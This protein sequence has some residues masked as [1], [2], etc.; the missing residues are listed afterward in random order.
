MRHLTR[1]PALALLLVLAL[2]LAP[3]A[4]A[5]CGGDDAPAEEQPAQSAFV[6]DWAPVDASLDITW[7]GDEGRSYSL[8]S[9]GEGGTLEV[10]QQGDAITVTLV[11]KSGGRTDPMPADEEGEALAFAIPISEEMPTEATLTSTGDGLA[12]LA[13]ADSDM[14]WSFKKSGAGA[15][16]D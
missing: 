9:G 13:F 12:D 16:G 6:G 5:A 7:G 15:T 4:L 3:A 14:T 11:G 8:S 1:R 2:A 10:A